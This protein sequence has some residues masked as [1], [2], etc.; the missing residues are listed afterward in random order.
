MLKKI[1]MRFE[2]IG[3][4]IGRVP[5]GKCRLDPT[6]RPGVDHTVNRVPTS[7]IIL[8]RNLFSSNVGSSPSNPDVSGLVCRCKCVEPTSNLRSCSHYAI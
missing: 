5:I 7:T 1:I 4:I 8:G 3:N 2:H 6:S